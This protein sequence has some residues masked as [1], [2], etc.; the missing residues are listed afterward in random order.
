MKLDLKIKI[1][2]RVIFNDI[3]PI[4]D[5]KTLDSEFEITTN[6]PNTPNEH[7]NKKRKRDE[8]DIN[9]DP[10]EKFRPYNTL[11]EFIIFYNDS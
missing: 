8:Y 5:F 11:E 4:I 6:P 9:V 3:K 1:P 7:I 10:S 2:K